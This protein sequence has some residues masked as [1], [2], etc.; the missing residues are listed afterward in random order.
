MTRGVWNDKTPGKR[1]AA[2]KKA[3]SNRERRRR[4]L[5]DTAEQRALHAFL[6]EGGPPLPA[7]EQGS[8]VDRVLPGAGI[9]ELLAR[10]RSRHEAEAAE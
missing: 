2:A 1:S 3:A 7:P 9:S 8:A 10:I 6:H 4:M 5:R